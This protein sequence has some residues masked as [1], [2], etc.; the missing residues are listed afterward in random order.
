MSERADPPAGLPA[1]RRVAGFG[2]A[3][4]RRAVAFFLPLAVLAANAS[5]DGGVPVPPAG[6]LDAAGQDSAN[7]VAWQPRA[8]VRIATVTVTWKQGFVLA[9]RSLAL[10]ERQERN[11][12]VL[13]WVAWI[14]TIVALAGASLAAARQ[15]PHD[16]SDSAAR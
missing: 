10:V 8:G 2:R 4:L 16:A 14:L 13:A 12:L 5:L 9:G 6:V 1:E 7:V 3:E 11:T 15:W